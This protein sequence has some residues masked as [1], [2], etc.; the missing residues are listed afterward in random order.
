MIRLKLLFRT[1]FSTTLTFPSKNKFLNKAIVINRHRS[2]WLLCFCFLCFEGMR[3]RQYTQNNT[4]IQQDIIYAHVNET[5]F[6]VHTIRKFAYIHLCSICFTSN[7]THAH[8]KWFNLWPHAKRTI[9]T[10]WFK[11]AVVAPSFLWS[12][13]LFCCYF[14]CDSITASVTPNFSLSKY[15]SSRKIELFYTKAIFLLFCMVLFCFVLFI[16]HMYIV[17]HERTM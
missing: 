3:L 13:L 9:S 5:D 10:K 1:Y 14:Y 15:C 7:R 8:T 4:T 17:Q 2:P 12:I 16:L 11:F 6:N